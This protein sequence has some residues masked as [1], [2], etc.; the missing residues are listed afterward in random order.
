VEAV[1]Q[2]KYLLSWNV[3]NENKACVLGKSPNLVFKAI[4]GLGFHY[5]K[6]DVSLQPL[7][8]TRALKT[9]DH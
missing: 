5:L 9:H 3:T 7:F 4:E 8:T 2:T 1:K 6:L